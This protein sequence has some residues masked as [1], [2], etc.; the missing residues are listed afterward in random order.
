MTGKQ[1]K[2]KKKK[3]IGSR[4]YPDNAKRDSGRFSPER[5]IPRRIATETRNRE[6]D[7]VMMA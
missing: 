4:R 3:K 6:V 7:V 5:E 2:K 1:K